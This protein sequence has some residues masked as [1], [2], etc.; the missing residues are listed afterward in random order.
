MVSYTIFLVFT[1]LPGSILR[2]SNLDLYYVGYTEVP[3]AAAVR[4]RL[5]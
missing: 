1:V 4:P 2:F 5:S 3:A